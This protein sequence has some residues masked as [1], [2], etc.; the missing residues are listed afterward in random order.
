[1][2]KPFSF[3]E[4]HSKVAQTI[5]PKPAATLIVLRREGGQMRV[6]MGRRSEHHVFLPGKL[7]FPGGRV[8]PGDYRAPALRELDPAVEAKL[9]L[10]KKG[11]GQKL[12]RALALAAIRET[13]E[14]TGYLIGE[15]TG[16]VRRLSKNPSWRAFHEAGYLPDLEPVRLVARAI[17]P[18]GRSRRFDARFFALFDDGGMER[19]TTTDRELL[20]PQWLTFDEVDEADLPLITRRVLAD[21]AGRLSRDP[22]LSPDGSVPFHFMHYGRSKYATL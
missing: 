13:F 4:P 16:A 11:A 19:V 15:K 10:E 18:P 17:T 7:V 9:A 14:E 1:M 20:D 12:G 3:A 21:L 8:E 6:L 5:R 22:D 2:S